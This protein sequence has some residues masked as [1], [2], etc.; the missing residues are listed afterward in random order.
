MISKW[1]YLNPLCS[2]H[3]LD[4]AKYVFFSSYGPLFFN[5]IRKIIEKTLFLTHKGDP[6]D[7]TKPQARF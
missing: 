6:S 7:Q 2:K 1:R 4:L 5:L 3:T